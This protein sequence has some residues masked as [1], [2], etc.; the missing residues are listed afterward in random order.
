MKK[1]LFSIMIVVLVLGASISPAQAAQ[2]Q[3]FYLEKVCD[4]SIAENICEITSAEAPFEVLVGGTIEYFDHAYFENPAGIAHEAST[5]LVTAM[6]GSTAIGH[7][8]WVW[9]PIGFSGRYILTS[10]T[11]VFTGIHAIG[12][13][14][15]LDMDTWTFSITGTYFYAP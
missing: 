8:S 10:G 5:I 4:G 2:P 3:S 15:L 6:D 11:G 14:E 7:V 13:V 1:I 9:G 12:R